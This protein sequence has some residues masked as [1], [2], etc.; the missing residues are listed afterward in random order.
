MHSIAK[1]SPQPN[2]EYA[3]DEIFNVDSSYMPNGVGKTF[4]RNIWYYAV[5]GNDLKPGKMIAKTMLGEPV[6]VGRDSNGVAFALKDV[7]P[8]QAVPLSKGHFDGKQVVCCFHGWAF[9]TSGVCEQIPSLSECQDQAIC[10]KFKAKSYPC[11]EVQGNVWVFFGDRTENLPDVPEA[12]GLEG[13]SSDKTKSTLFIPTHIDYAVAGLIDPAHVPYV[14]NAWW[15]R[16]AKSMKEKVKKYVPEATGWTMVKHKPAAHSIAFKLI[17]RFIET[18]ISF[19]LPGCRLEYI[20]FNGRTILSG[21]T[22]LTPIDDTHTEM[23]HTTYWTIPFIAPI[24]TPIVNYFVKEFLGQDKRI[25][26]MQEIGLR[27]NPKLSMFVKDAG[28]PGA[29]YFQL[30]KEWS[31][32][33]SEGRAFENPIKESVLRWRS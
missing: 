27:S 12:P 1:F 31:E 33:Q 10:S 25:A 32:S 15:W 2:N 11:R 18:E 23:N 29:W 14:H 4:T 6:L 17:G 5:A 28:M 20:Q 26:E 19:R 24:V 9:N 21:I 13:L 7:C 8:H 30:K 22:T 16:S 3:F